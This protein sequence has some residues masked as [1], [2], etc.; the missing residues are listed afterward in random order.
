MGRYILNQKTAIETGNEMWMRY[1]KGDDTALESIVILYSDN[2][3]FYI[4]SYDQKYINICGR[5]YFVRSVFKA[6]HPCKNDFEKN[7]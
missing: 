5:R 2:L 6:G 7:L 1:R 4:S 3:L